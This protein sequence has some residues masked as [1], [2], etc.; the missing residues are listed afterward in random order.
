MEGVRNWYCNAMQ[1]KT[2]A[3][4]LKSYAE[5]HDSAAFAELVTRHGAMVYHVCFRVLANQHEAEDA[6]QAAFMTLAGKASR[7]RVEGTVANWLHTVAR[8][9][10]LTLRRMRINRLQRESAA[11]EMLAVER[12]EELGEPG[13]EAVLRILDEELAALSAAQR[14]AVILRHLQ[15]RSEKEAAAMVGCAANT[16]SR[17]AFNGISRLRLRLARRGCALGIPALVGVLEAESQA[18]IPQTLIPSLMAVPK[19]MTAGASA[20][21]GAGNLMAVMEGTMRA[22]FMGKMKVVGVGVIAAVVLGMAG[23]VAVKEVRKGVS[24]AK[25]ELK[26]CIA[27]GKTAVNQG[28]TPIVERQNARKKPVK[29]Q[30][31]KDPVHRD[32]PAEAD[33]ALKAMKEKDFTSIHEVLVAWGREDHEAAVRWAT[34]LPDEV[35]HSIDQVF[36]GSGGAST[37]EITRSLLMSQVAL[38]WAEVFP[39]AAAQW[40]E[41]LSAKGR[42]REIALSVVSSSWAR[43]DLPSAVDWAERLPEG[44]DRNEAMFQVA[45]AWCHV[46]GVHSHRGKL[47][48]PS[49]LPFSLRR[50]K[51]MRF[52]QS[53]SAFSP[54]GCA[55]KLT[56]STPGFLASPQAKIVCPELYSRL[57]SG[58]SHR[59]MLPALGLKPLA[60]TSTWICGTVGRTCAVVN[61]EGNVLRVSNWAPSTTTAPG[62][63]AR[64]VNVLF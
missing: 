14:E 8:Q 5:H 47:F 34:E 3:E 18:A 46:D 56:A 26:P 22:L 53:G 13:R 12:G 20:G 17:R 25:G 11:A 59:A 9:A 33:R 50:E 31:R 40:V 10:A 64:R 42:V 21:A 15:G 45:T 41:Q 60:L 1:T 2:D 32:F 7:I 49:P 57:H 58:L 36:L 37:E 62:P 35:V 51:S 23:V 6:S 55:L 27:L 44:N 28:K 16:L 30:E 48:T 24:E 39:A 43:S 61:V 52:G 29:P 38:G 63:R 19:L 54:R 4:L